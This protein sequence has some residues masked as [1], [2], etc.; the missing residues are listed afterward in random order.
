MAS[1]EILAIRIWWLGTFGVFQKFSIYLVVME[2]TAAYFSAQ[3]Q[4]TEEFHFYS[5][6]KWNYI[7][8]HQKS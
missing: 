7:G 3:F 6:K 1:N 4:D 2:K 8:M 5:F